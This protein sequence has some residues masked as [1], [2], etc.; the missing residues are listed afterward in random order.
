MAIF[1]ARAFKL[2][3]ESPMTF[4][5]MSP[6]M[7]SYSSVKKIVASQITT[8]FTDHTFKPNETLTRGQISAFIARAMRDSTQEFIDQFSDLNIE[9]VRYG[10]NDVYSD[11][12][13][14]YNAET[15]SYE[16]QSFN[17]K[18]DKGFYLYMYGKYSNVGNYFVQ[19]DI[20]NSLVPEY[21]NEFKEDLKQME[22]HKYNQKLY[23]NLV[24]IIQFYRT[25]N[26]QVEYRTYDD[27]YVTF[28]IKEIESLVSKH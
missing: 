13:V 12:V 20:L 4:K 15:R 17:K 9:N 6:N 23:V 7:A 25:K 21:A 14:T 22:V 19:L 16:I 27:G 18:Y 1:L 5:D 3:E 28:D 2:N 11:A 26:L 8:G 10:I 24:N